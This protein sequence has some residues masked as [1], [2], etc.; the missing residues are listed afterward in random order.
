MSR[1]DVNGDSLEYVLWG[2][3]KR[4]PTRDE[5]AHALG[6][7][8]GAYHRRIKK[9][10]YPNAED[11]RR[12]AAAFNLDPV[13]LQIRFGLIDENTGGF[14]AALSGEDVDHPTA[15]GTQGTGHANRTKQKIRQTKRGR[16]ESDPD[17]PAF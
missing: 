1:T 16:P 5:M 12:I 11:L 14:A 17:S 9:T 7:G 10:D 3:I 4:R 6:L 13:S 8:P 15:R 2:L